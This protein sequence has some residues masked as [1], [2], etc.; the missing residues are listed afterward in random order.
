[1]R[2]IFL[3]V[4][5]EFLQR[6]R[7]KSFWL[8]LLL[9]PLFFLL[10]MIVPIGLSMKKDKQ[11][12]VLYLD[13]TGLLENYLYSDAHLAFIPTHLR[14]DQAMELTQTEGYNG[15]LRLSKDS[16]GWHCDYFGKE[17]FGQSIP[18]QLQPIVQERIRHFELDQRAA[19]ELPPVQFKTTASES[20]QMNSSVQFVAGLFVALLVLVFI[21][22]YAY[23]VLRGVVEEKQ[24]RISELLLTSVKPMH[25]ITGKIIGIASVAFLQ[26]AVW[27]GLAGLLSLT[28]YKYFQLARF[29]DAHLAQTLR[30]T[31]DMAQSLEMNALLN[32]T[33]SLELGFLLGGFLFYFVF[34]Y[35]LYSALFAM[36]G[37]A[38]GN[39][40]D[41]QQLAMPLTL[42]L[43]LP[44]VLLQVVVENPSSTLTKFLSLFPLTSPT[45]MLI[46]LPFGVPAFELVSSGIVLLL[47]FVGVSYGASKVYRLGVLLYGKKLRFAEIWKWLQA[48]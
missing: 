26:M 9:G 47:A 13:E 11:S 30:H 22:Q 27:F 40:A 6:V 10:A 21:N 24:N 3:I 15:L 31:T 4:E 18:A 16:T 2:A 28:V 7:Q 25:F 38:V 45:A 35:L 5:R 19:L 41:A 32:A 23:M 20:E 39:D 42:P 1:M 8:V 48:G 29:T 43:V 34:G 17:G 44:V 37:V 12:E 36:V 14:L 46:R 33:G